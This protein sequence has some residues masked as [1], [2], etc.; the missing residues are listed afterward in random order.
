MIQVDVLIYGGGVTGLWTLALLR[1][2][3]YRTLLLENRA[4]GAGQTI[5][6]QGIIHGGLK[7]AIPGVRDLD[8]TA[9]IREMPTRWKRNLQGNDIPDL[10]SVTVLSDECLLWIPR[11]S[12]LNITRMRDRAGLQLL[13]TKPRKLPKNEWPNILFGSASV[14]AVAEPVID[15]GTLLRAIAAAHC[16]CVKQYDGD[17]PLVDSKV[18]VLAAG[19]GNADLLKRFGYDPN[20]MQLRPLCMILVRGALPRLYGH[21]IEAGKTAL[22]ITTH[23]WYDQIVW[24]IGG[25]IAEKYANE[26]NHVTVKEGA[27]EALRSCLPGLDIQRLQMATYP[28]FRAEARTRQGH[29]PGGA[30]V[31]VVARNL[32][33]AW[34]TKLALAPVVA[35]EILNEVSKIARPS[36]DTDMNL[37]GW[38]APPIAPYPWEHIQWFSVA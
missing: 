19:K 25:Q 4:L 20:M 10:S 14:Y 9:A 12:R 38:S 21:C 28:A 29:R 27:L 37:S 15:T 34:P 11:G 7:Y 1:H 13:S 30:H 24:Q 16:G 18:T 26:T 35:A 33:A 2:A 32:I 6:A 5:Q 36:G 17:L 3:G 8:A 22:T 31:V 23:P